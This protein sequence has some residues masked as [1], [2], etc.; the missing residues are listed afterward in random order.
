MNAAQPP[1]AGPSPS[2]KRREPQHLR[3]SADRQ[4]RRR[5]HAPTGSTAA[6]PPTPPVP[7]A[8]TAYQSLF[9]V[10]RG[11]SPPRPPG[12]SRIAPATA[13]GETSAPALRP[14]PVTRP[15]PLNRKPTLGAHP[16]LR[17]PSQRPRTHIRGSCRAPEIALES[18]VELATTRPHPLAS[19]PGGASSGSSLHARP[20]KPAPSALLVS[21]PSKEVNLR[22]RSCRPNVTVISYVRGNS[23]IQP[24][25]TGAQTVG[26]W[27]HLR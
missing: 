3:E 17:W 5:L 24:K 2:P 27:D 19:W 9:H 23:T 8:P 16:N 11:P 26:A 15:A 12:A 18:P 14:S 13:S 22:V 4:L 7:E 20:E 25:S 1:T 6:S 10:K 21:R